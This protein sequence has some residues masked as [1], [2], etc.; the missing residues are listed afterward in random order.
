MKLNIIIAN[1]SVLIRKGLECILAQVSDF[2]LAAICENKSELEELL[3]LHPSDLLIADTDSLGI[4]AKDIESYRK[5]NPDLKILSIT[6]LL[7]KDEFRTTILSGVN[8]CLLNECD[9]DEIK[10][11]IYKTCSGEQ[12]LCGK[13]AEVLTSDNVYKNSHDLRNVSCA[14]FGIT[15]REMQVIVLIAEGLSNKEIADKLCLST[16]TVNT[17]RKNIM[18]KL[19]INNTAGVVMFAVRNNLLDQSGMLSYN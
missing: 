7:G 19:G 17:H 8:S 6:A 16:H 10:E 2:N 9:F 1:N 18:S 4:R 12:F 3:K 15:E 11:A 5:K 14:G 13:I